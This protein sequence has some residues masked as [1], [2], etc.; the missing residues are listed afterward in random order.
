M[1]ALLFAGV[2]PTVAQN[3]SEFWKTPGAPPLKTRKVNNCA[4]GVGEKLTYSVNYGVINA[5]SATV[6]VLSDTTRIAGRPNYHLVSMAKSNKVFSLFFKVEDRIDSYQDKEG[7]FTWESRVRLRE[8]N[9]KADRYFVFDHYV[10]TATRNNKTVTKIPEFCTDAMGTYFYFR[11]LEFDVGDTIFL[12][13]YESRKV[14]ELAIPIVGRETIKVP[15]GT[16]DCYKIIP[17]LVE[18]EAVFQSKGRMT[19][20][21]TADQHRYLAKVAS[22]VIF[23]TIH[24]NLTE[25]QPGQIECESPTE[26]D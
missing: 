16:F 1:L 3:R 13:I 22:E 6:E 23:G 8:G 15:A 2:E 19:L 21:V 12:P 14:Y 10:K 11:T 9:Y 24:I 7:L 17:Q 25:I 18:N 26:N 20:W 5:G 4:F